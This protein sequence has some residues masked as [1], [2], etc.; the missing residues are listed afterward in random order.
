[1]PQIKHAGQIKYH[2]SQYDVSV[3]RLVVVG[4]GE[5]ELFNTSI[6]NA[7]ENRHVVFQ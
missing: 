4:K 2:L 3:Y 5:E 7:A 1:M 6:P